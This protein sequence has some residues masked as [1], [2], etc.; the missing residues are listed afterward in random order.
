MSSHLDFEC[1]KCQSIIQF[2][3]PNKFDYDCPNC[4][5]PTLV[6][7]MPDDAQIKDRLAQLESKTSVLTGQVKALKDIL[8]DYQGRLE[9]AEKIA[10]HL[11]ARLQDLEDD[12]DEV[13]VLN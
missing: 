11:E 2:A 12:T 13:I 4:L 3:V 10:R 5:N 8:K 6:P 1:A 9:R 7:F